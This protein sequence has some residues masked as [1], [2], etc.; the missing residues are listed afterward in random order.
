MVAARSIFDRVQIQICCVLD[1][2]H[3]ILVQ[4]DLKPTLMN[5]SAHL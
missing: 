4:Q 5:G 2:T 1:N 3:C